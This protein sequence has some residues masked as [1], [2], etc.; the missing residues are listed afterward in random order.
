MLTA[1]DF[2]DQLV[3]EADEIGVERTNWNLPF[4]FQ[5]IE[6]AVADLIPEFDLGRRRLAAHTAGVGLE[7]LA[8]D[9]LFPGFVRDHVRHPLTPALSPTSVWERG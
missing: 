8:V 7:R 9:S 4:E 3:F 6:A 1:V 2:D 5:S